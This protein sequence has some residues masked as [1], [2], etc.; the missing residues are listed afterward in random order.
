M[1]GLL[2]SDDPGE[3]AYLALAAGLLGGRG[4]FRQ[5]LGSGLMAAQNTFSQAE[6]RK[7]DAAESK[8]AMSLRDIQLKDLIR[9]YRDSIEQPGKTQAAIA[10]FPQA[11]EVAGPPDASGMPPM[12]S[13][14]S[15]DYMSWALKVYGLDPN[16]S[17]FGFKAADTINARD[18][19]LH[20]QRVLAQQA[21]D[22][23]A[24]A[25]RRE[26]AARAERQQADLSMKQLLAGQANETRK[27]LAAL[28]SQKRDAPKPMPPSALK[29]QQDELDAIGAASSIN[30]DLSAYEKKINDKKLKLSLPEN[31]TARALNYIGAST[32][33]TQEFAS[34]KA[35]MEKMRNASLQ[36]NKGV[37]TEG[38]AVRAW[39]EL[40]ENLNDSSVVKKRLQEIQNI[41]KRAVVLRKN[42]IDVIRA[43]YQLSPLDTSTIE[44]VPAAPVDAGGL[45]SIDAIDAELKRRQGK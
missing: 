31:L 44:N 9:K 15:G 23:K 38:D 28:A 19:R 40:F 27:M 26:L 35:D 45:P 5:N 11:G 34:F 1:A 21:A 12:A 20:N 25:Q 13:P 32:P 18:E 36:L 17:Q 30:A 14:S 2:F 33:E 10:S 41:N 37:Q 8:Q 16:L 24:E 7:L 3:Q 22:A 43:N 39:N 29:L 42:N 6:K 4:S